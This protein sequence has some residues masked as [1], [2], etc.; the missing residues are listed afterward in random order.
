MEQLGNNP[1]VLR[2]AEKTITYSPAFKVSAVQANQAGMFPIGKD[3]LFVKGY[4]QITKAM[5]IRVPSNNILS[6][7]ESVD[8]IEHWMVYTASGNRCHHNRYVHRISINE[9]CLLTNYRSSDRLEQIE[10]KRM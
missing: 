8:A 10:V 7:R 4:E 5:P 9:Q 2:V 6:N 3:I 1:N